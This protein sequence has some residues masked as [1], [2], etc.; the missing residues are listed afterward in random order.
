ME[1]RLVIHRQDDVYKAR[2]VESDGQEG[3]PFTLVLPLTAAD[4]SDLRWYLETYPQFPGAGDLARAQSIERQMEGWGR[5]LFEAL[6]G[7]AES[8]E[9]YRNLLDADGPR[10]LT[11]G[12]TDPDVLAQPWEML[13]DAR[14]PLAFRGVIVRRQLKGSGKTR[15]FDLGLPL[16]VLLIVSRPTGAGFIDPRTSTAPLLDALDALPGQVEIGFCDPPTLPRLEEMVSDARKARQ[17]YHIVHFDGHGTYL[18]L[19]GI[20]ALC[21]EGAEG[22]TDLVAGPA[23][24]DLLTRLDVPLVVLEACRTA[25]LSDRPVFGSVAPALLQS[26]VG[27]VVAFSH[28]VHVRAATLLVERFYRELCEGQTVGQALEEGRVALR[29]DPKRWLHRGPN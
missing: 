25:S 27:S 11:L 5:A 3:D 17:P 7:T 24:G 4:T 1:A 28:A 2:W 10:L 16:R 13:R 12:A 8:R 23:L 21:F 14:G 18:P 19:T 9:V 6:F 22:K 15:R 26:G 29:A 20:G